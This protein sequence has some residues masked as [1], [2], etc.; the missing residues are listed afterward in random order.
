MR[1][2]L[3][4]FLRSIAI[5]NG[6]MVYCYLVYDV[7]S[8]RKRDINIRKLENIRQV[9]LYIRFSR[10]LMQSKFTLESF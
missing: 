2:F 9:K 6:Q 8:R 10:A 1:R 3:K 4:V 5:C 7:I